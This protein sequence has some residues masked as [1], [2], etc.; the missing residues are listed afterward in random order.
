[1][2]RNYSWAV[3]H[4]SPLWMSF[5]GLEN[6]MSKNHLGYRPYGAIASV[7]LVQPGQIVHYV[8]GIGSAS[9]VTSYR[10]KRIEKS[11]D[12]ARAFAQML[13]SNALTRDGFSLLDCNV[14]RMNNYNSNYLFHDEDLAQDYCAWAMKNTCSPNYD[15]IY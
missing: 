1:M 9:R 15:D 8:Y 5:S 13:S 10:V 7:E 11:E 6:N 3:Y 12:S 4:C 14:V 2:I